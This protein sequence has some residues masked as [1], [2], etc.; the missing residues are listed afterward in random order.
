MHS[1]GEK[2]SILHQEKNFANFATSSHWQKF[3]FFLSR[4]KDGIEDMATITALV[5]N[6]STKFFCNTKVAGLGKILIQQRFL[7]VY[8]ILQII[9][10]VLMLL[11]LKDFEQNQ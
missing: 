7:H 5:E 3:Y 2:C 9:L 8:S 6:F 10:P 11:L 1:P 4:I